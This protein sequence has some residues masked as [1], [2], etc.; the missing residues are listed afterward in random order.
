M[1]CVMTHARSAAPSL[2]PRRPRL[3]R[4]DDSLDWATDGANWPNR[5]A[6]RFVKT[7]GLTWHV[8]IMGHGPILLLAHG[9]GGST[10]SWRDL[11]PCL[12][13]DFTVVAPDLQGHGFTGSPGAS[14]MTV[15][16]MAAGLGALLLALGL[17]PMVTVG[18]S[19]G[20]AVLARLALSGTIAAPAVLVALNGAML[21][22]PGVAGYV[23]RS[24][25]L[26]LASTPA[27]PW[28]LSRRVRRQHV[29]ERLIA[30][31]GSRL[32][33]A[34][35]DA[36]A[37]L[38]G[39]PGHLRNMLLM[40]ARWDL[41]HFVL[42]LPR[43]PCRLVLV[44]AGCDRAVPAHAARQTAARVPGSELVVHPGYG[45]LSHEE[46]P[47]ETAAIIRRAA[48]DVLTE[49]DAHRTTGAPGSRSAA[50]SLCLCPG[51]STERQ[52]IGE[53]GSQS[54]QASGGPVHEA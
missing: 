36:Y 38:L 37:R 19:A 29:V 23:F 52:P 53:S 30:N 10:G 32:D 49:A 43:L 17:S 34:G 24:L 9:A 33:D 31:T 22:M 25:A 45:H 2:W 50:G 20:A 13:R 42:E 44:A 18:H 8:Q 5:L 48:R 14:G 47:E 39:N 51:S 28:L 46:A 40:L 4:A 7:A 16:A 41:R 26:L 35:L 27:L 1:T 12:A 54:R 11:M 6:S 3:R 15:D 21:P